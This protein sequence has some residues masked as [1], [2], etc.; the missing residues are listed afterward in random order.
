M[1]DGILIGG[2][3]AGQIHLNP[4]YANRHGLVAGATGTGKTVTLQCLAEGFSDLGVPV[5]LADVKGDISGLSQAGKPHP[6]IDERVTKI[7]IAN[8][9]QRAY[10]VAFWDLFGKQGTPVRSTITEMGPQLLSRLLQLN[11]T[12]ESI[13]TLV[14]EFADDE[15][16]LLVDLSDLRTTLEYLGNNSKELGTGFGVSKASVN[17]I[18]RRLL[19][20]ERE[21]GEAFFAEPALQLT[22][23]MQ[24]SRDGRGVIN[25]LAA[26]KLIMNPR[27][28]ST[29]LLWLLSEL[30]E[31]LPE[32]GDPEQPVLV[33][34]FDEAHLLFKDAPK[35][36][37]EKIEQVVRLIR[38]KGVGVYFISQSPSDIPDSVLAQL[39]NRVQHALRAYTP[40]EQKAV[41]VAAQSFRSNPDLDTVKAIT[42]LGVGEALVSTLQEK[43]IPAPVQRVLIRPPHSRLGKATQAERKQLLASDPNMKRYAKAV[44][45]RSAHEILLERTAQRVKQQQEAEAKKRATKSKS[46]SRRGSRETATEAFVKSMA[47]AAGTSVG[48]KLLRGILGSLLK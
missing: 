19:M 5:F 41:K 35:P 4:R 46:S 22:D 8:Y 20:L 2:S 29:F 13:M 44:D 10:P 40:K 3:K 24:T 11:E 42:E 48:S 45:P 15:G 7:D 36:L 31:N 25:V 9:H 33:F 18:L 47:R 14:F 39:G 26:D 16:M 30:F 12:Q 34:F 17:A 32:L 38:S 37:L 27:L 21:G 6:K 43:G 23:F 1:S 28:Y